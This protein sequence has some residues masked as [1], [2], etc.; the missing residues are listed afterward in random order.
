MH[1]VR[2]A[3][4]RPVGGGRALAVE[5]PAGANGP[6]TPRSHL[7]FAVTGTSPQAKDGMRLLALFGK[8]KADALSWRSQLDAA[9]GGKLLGQALGTGSKKNVA[10]AALRISE[11][12]E[13]NR[14][15]A[16]NT[17]TANCCLFTST[18]VWSR[19]ARAASARGGTPL[20]ADGGSQY[21]DADLCTYAAR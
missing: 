1:G 14:A 18:S 21:A 10:W 8:N 17:H 2:W 20:Y 5:V 3:G 16:A 11:Q 6:E 9:L 12:H 15:A 13:L 19:R 4:E 7:L